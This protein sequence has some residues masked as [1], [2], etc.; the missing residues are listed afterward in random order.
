[1]RWW[2]YAALVESAAIMLVVAANPL[3][4]VARGMRACCGR[5]FVALI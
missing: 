4:C 3:E 1:M 2:R 5:P